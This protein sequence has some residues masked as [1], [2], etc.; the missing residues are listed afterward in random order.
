[1]D[2]IISYFESINPVLAAFLATLFTW[3][4]TALGASLV[5]LFKNE[6]GIL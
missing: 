3:A 5:F 6:Q 1:M 2:T 4:L